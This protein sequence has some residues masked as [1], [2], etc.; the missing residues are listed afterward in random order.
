MR[1][2]TTI[3]LATTFSLTM[4]FAANAQADEARCDVYSKIGGSMVN[5]MLPLTMQ[6]F[7]NITTGKDP[8]LSSQMTEKMIAGMNETDFATLAELGVDGAGLM[9]E[10]A[11]QIAVELLIS[12]QASSAREVQAVMKETCM[13]VGVDTILDNQRQA[14]VNVNSSLGK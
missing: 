7:I 2:F 4:P 6:D 12:G 10:A 1:Y 3:I 8:K 5:F 13:S 14:R 9:G 11:G